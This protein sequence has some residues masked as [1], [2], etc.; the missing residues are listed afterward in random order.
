MM[1]RIGTV[2]SCSNRWKIAAAGCWL[3]L[4]LALTVGLTAC[5]APPHAEPENTKLG[6]VQLGLG[7]TDAPAVE[8]RWWH[9][10]NDSQ[11]NSLIEKAL[12]TNPNLTAALARIREARAQTEELAAGRQ[13]IVT[14]DGEEVRQHYPKRFLYPP[15]LGGGEYWQGQVGFNL[16]W[17]LDFWGRQAALIEAAKANAR[18]AVLDAAGAR[19]AVAGALAQSYVDFYRA[20]TLADI[21]ARAVQ[22][23]QSIVDITRGRVAAGLS[24]SIELHSAESALARAWSSKVQSDTA[25]DIAMHALATI[26][27]EGAEAYPKFVRPT[28]DLQ[29][30]LPLPEALPA[31]LIARRPDVLAAQALVEAAYAGR[32]A[33]H[34]AFYPDVNLTAFAGFEAI[35]ITNLLRGEDSEY[36]VGPAIHLPLFESGKLKS[37]YR[38]ATAQTDAAISAYNETVL[39]AVQQVADQLS[40]VRSYARQFDEDRQALGEA[41]TTYEMAEHHYRTGLSG[42]LTVLATETQVLEARQTCANVLAAQAAARVSLLLAV[43]GDFDPAHVTGTDT[44]STR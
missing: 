15:P 1:N 37:R 27:G 39:R 21:A 4:S 14:F 36:G 40:L 38:E 19:L 12:S 5:V 23:W 35:A 13:P 25:V 30:A 41:E 31:D 10:F 2:L 44:S 22:Q 16:S 18:Y 11:L 9:T 24:T 34:Q 3:Q 17:C 7:N 26:T 20:E 43:G 28:A 6:S 32:K 33:A 29:A 42:Y 8:D